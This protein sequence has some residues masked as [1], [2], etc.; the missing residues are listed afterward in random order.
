M[1]ISDNDS[2][3]ISAEVVGASITPQLLSAARSRWP[4]NELAVFDDERLFYKEADERSSVLAR[5][6]LASGVGKGAHVGI[7]LPNN[8][9]FII[10]WL[11][12]T[13]IGAVGV[14]IS[15][16][17]T[18]AELAQLIRHADLQS[19]IFCP[20]YLKNDYVS[21]LEEALPS[22]QPGQQQS[23]TE[24]P[25]LRRLWA[26]SDSAPQWASSVENP[27]AATVSPEMLAAAENEVHE[28]DQA[29]IIYTSGSTSEPK[30]VV[31]SQGSLLRQSV[32]QAHAKQ[33]TQRDRVYSA[34]PF[35]W[36]GGL[37]YHL[38]PAMQ[39]GST[40]LGCKATAPSETL[41]FLERERVTIFLG[42]PHSAQAL[43]SEPSFAARKLDSMRAGNLFAAM[44]SHL[45][46][47]NRELIADGLGMTET[48][49]PH[50][51]GHLS[52]LSEEYRGSF[53]W[54]SPGM[55]YRVINWETGEDVPDG[56]LGE[57]LVRGNTLMSG[58]YKRERSD[59]FHPDGW[60]ATKDMVIRRDGH[61]FFQ[62]RLDDVVKIKG[63]NISP[64]EVEA[65]LN[66]IPGVA[67]SIVTGLQVGGTLRLAAVLVTAPG[68]TIDTDALPALLRKSLSAYKVPSLFTTLPVEQ[69]PFRSSGKVD[70]RAL[71]ALLQESFV[72][73]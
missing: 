67:Q 7:L 34:M 51:A 69:L 62:G 63:A 18:A 33:Y 68:A 48:A 46:P 32:K 20:T 15:T 6:L 35:F 37:S 56:E 55:E 47:K 11:A 70:R 21:R 58:M 54:A 9:K 61:I 3:R 24:A 59:V 22:L 71:L 27:N 12:V 16:F 26:W 19:L 42:W 30:G 8:A 5:Q 10:T 2:L 13:R 23:L 52:S 40:I 65:V 29:A 31:H 44:P 4:N 53:G 38:L 64:R 50:S 60:Y 14:P 66:E 25:F 57:L 28:S 49:G 45:Q 1:A 39:A 17:S 73:K 72:E 36:V 41:D 43:E